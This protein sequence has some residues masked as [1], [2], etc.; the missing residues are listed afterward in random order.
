MLLALFTT[1]VDAQPGPDAGAQHR[2]GGG[3]SLAR[4][5]RN[6]GLTDEQ[7]RQIREIRD[8]GGSGEEIRAVLTEEQRV[9]MQERRRQAQ[10]RIQS[11]RNDPGRYYIQ[12][13]E[14]P[15]ADPDEG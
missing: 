12:P 7:V 4:M 1:A 3:D 9:M 15:P 5:Q 10:A 14:D 13:A 2:S 8:R 6:L 11:G